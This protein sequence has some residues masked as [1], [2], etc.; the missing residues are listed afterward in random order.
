MLDRFIIVCYAHIKLK[1]KV[2]KMKPDK[3][4]KQEII[5]YYLSQELNEVE[6]SKKYNCSLYVIEDVL[7]EHGVRRS[8]TAT[9]GVK[10]RP[11]YDSDEM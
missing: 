6:L 3:K 9:L 5:N 8:Y 10:G 11:S 7:M 2:S 1:R 4:Q